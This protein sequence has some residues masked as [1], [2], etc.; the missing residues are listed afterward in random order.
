[1]PPRFKETALPRP[2]KLY[3]NIL[4]FEISKEMFRQTAV[5]ECL[6]GQVHSQMGEE[7]FAQAVETI[8]LP[9]LEDRFGDSYVRY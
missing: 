1:M 9:H 2:C 6:Q 4:Y 5:P 8:S 7:P 3:L